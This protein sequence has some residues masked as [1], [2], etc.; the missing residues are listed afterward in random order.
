[1]ISGFSN[2]ISNAPY[3]FYI[4]G[5]L[6]LPYCLDKIAQGVGCSDL[7]SQIDEVMLVFA[8]WKNSEGRFLAEIFTSARL[9]RELI[10]HCWCHM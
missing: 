4:M 1:M 7:R 10:V 3:L 8:I 9:R 5:L 6:L 2:S